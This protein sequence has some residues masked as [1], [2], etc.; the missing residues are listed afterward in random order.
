MA[1]GVVRGF[2]KHH[3]PHLLNQRF[4]VSFLIFIFYARRMGIVKLLQRRVCL[5]SLLAG[6]DGKQARQ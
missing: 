5:Q 1:K 3:V 6:D 2:F 4:W